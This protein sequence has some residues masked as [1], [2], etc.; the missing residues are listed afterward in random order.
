MAFA[1]AELRETVAGDQIPESRVKVVGSGGDD[2]RQRRMNA[3][4]VDR[5]T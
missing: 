3:Q 1:A 5:L 2:E 4:I